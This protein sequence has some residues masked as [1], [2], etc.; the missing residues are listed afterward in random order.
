MRW[1]LVLLSLAACA[2][3]RSDE[4]VVDGAVTDAPNQGGDARPIDA[5][6]SGTCAQ[7][8]TGTLATWSF[9]GQAGNQT[10]TPATSQATGVTAGPVTRA[11]ALTANPGANSINSTNWPLT[12]TRDA[13]KY[14]AFTIA[15]PAGCT[16]SITGVNIDALS[17]GTGPASAQISTSADNY[18]AASSV[19]TSTAGLVAATVTD[20]S[21]MVEVRVF[22][23][24]A[25]AAGGTMRIQGALSVDGQLE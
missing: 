3:G 17:S 11:A 19:S 20:A 12:A 13:T 5:P 6:S 9:A 16:L 14:Y 24:A 15:P 2:R 25:T 8:F 1:T 22:G 4:P 23:Y 21:A 18:V 7:A 10:S